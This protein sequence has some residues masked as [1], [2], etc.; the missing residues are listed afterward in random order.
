MRKPNPNDVKLFEEFKESE[1]YLI[2]FW[3]NN[4]EKEIK[5]WFENNELKGFS[6]DDYQWTSNEIYSIYNGH[7]EFHEDTMEYKLDIIIELENAVN[8]KVT[9]L[10][11]ILTNYQLDELKMISKIRKDIDESDFTSELLINLI[12]ELKSSDKI[13][14]NN[15]EEVIEEKPKNE[16]V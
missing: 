4:K 10:T 11:L 1:D 13:Q 9:K 6:F 16:E 3:F 7:I 8:G 12:S 14:D 5:N 2:Q 15:P